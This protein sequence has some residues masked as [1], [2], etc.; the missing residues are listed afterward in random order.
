MVSWEFRG[1]PESR[2]DR[3]PTLIRPPP[4]GR[5]ES[6]HRPPPPP[7]ASPPMDNLTRRDA[8]ALSGSTLAG[9]SLAGLTVQ[10]LGAQAAPQTA[11]QEWPATLVERPLREG[12][13]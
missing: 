4:A 7:D 11:P 13:P 10:E 8:I 1:L 2:P 5:L 3:G 6:P 9:L 12:F